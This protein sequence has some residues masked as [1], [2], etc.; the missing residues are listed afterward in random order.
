MNVHSGFQFKRE[1][2]AF[3][4]FLVFH[5]TCFVEAID[6]WGDRAIPEASFSCSSVSDRSAV[7]QWSE[8][9]DGKEAPASPA[10][11]GREQE[12]E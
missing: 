9:F 4:G 2:L 3:W 7:G 1:T 10:T 12:H 8:L 6:H 5:R 11:D